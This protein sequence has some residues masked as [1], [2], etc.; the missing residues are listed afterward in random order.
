MSA[1]YSPEICAWCNG[2]GKR[3]SDRCEVCRGKGRVMVLQPPHKCIT[4]ECTGRTSTME[5]C[6]RC[7]GA[8]WEGVLQSSNKAG[9]Q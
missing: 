2:T 5:V 4:C 1:E 9:N 6:P 3:G 7:H 8:G